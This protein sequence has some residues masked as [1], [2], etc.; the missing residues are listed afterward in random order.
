MNMAVDCQHILGPDGPIARRL[1]DRYEQRPQQLRMAAAVDQALAQ[2]STLLVEAGTGVGKSFAYLLPAIRQIVEH[3]KRVVIS[4]HTISL[5]EQ[6]IEKDI[7]LLNAII[8]EE[9]TAVLVKGRSN[10]LSLR[11]L[12]LASQRQ[13]QLFH[14]APELRSLHAIEDWAYDTEDGTLSTL[15]T[16][17][18]GGVWDRVQSDAGNCMGRKCPTYNKCFYQAARRRMHNADLLIV[19]HALFFADLALRAEGASLLPDYDHVILDEAHMI[20]DVASDHFGL[21]LTDGGVRHLLGSLFSPRTHRGFL[22]SVTLKD[23]RERDVLDNAVQ[24]VIKAEMA[25]DQFFE[26]LAIWQQRHGRSN[27]RVYERGVIEN[28]ITPAMNELAVGLRLLMGKV[29]SEADQ[30]ELNAYLLRAQT[31]ATLADGWLEQKLEEAVYWAEIHDSFRRRIKVAASP[32]DVAPL[33]RQHLFNQ[34]NDEGEAIGVVLTSATLSTLGAPAADRATAISTA[35]SANDDQPGS[36]AVAGDL[37]SAAAG[38]SNGPFAHLVRRLGCEHADSLLLDSPFDYA[39]TARLIIQR[40]MP[41]PASGDYADALGPAVLE[42]IEQTSGGAFVLFTS[43]QLLNRVADWLGPRLAERE[44]PMLV[45]GRD[46]PRTLLL[47]RFKDC[48]SSVLL[49][50]DSFWQ[51]V[52][53]QGDALRNVIITKLPFAVPDRPLIEARLERIRQRG[54]NPFVEYQLPEAI[55]RFKQGFGRLIRSRTDRGQVVVLD[56]RIVSKSY[57]RRFIAALPGVPVDW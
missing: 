55:I 25:A 26:S 31:Y 37:P 34:R 54:G 47:Q 15:P 39:S 8:D 2:A 3:D 27:G 18:R 36:S 16:L 48:G 1:G 24:Q 19:N 30:Y 12:M 53:V 17:E 56:R 11:R 23:H 44:L 38:S 33:M 57:G 50:T 20:E 10:Y 28:T 7:P 43:Y 13:D 29:K 5:Q 21:G 51:G 49:G 22:T 41:D 4:T 45:Q 6:L 35:E 42:A 46:G 40:N 52:D 14:H 32:V 9:F